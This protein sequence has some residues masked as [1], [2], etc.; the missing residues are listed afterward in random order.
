MGDTTNMRDLINIIKYQVNQLNIDKRM[1][2]V[3]INPKFE[4]RKE[5]DEEIKRIDSVIKL[6]EEIYYGL[7]K[8]DYD[9]NY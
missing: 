6:Q 3:C 7:L 1:V 9:E 8:I 2:R 5:R 4:T